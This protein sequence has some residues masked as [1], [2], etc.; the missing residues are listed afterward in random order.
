MS[1]PIQGARYTVL[2]DPPTSPVSGVQYVGQAQ[3]GSL[4]DDP[5]WAIMRLTYASSDL[6]AVEWAA[7][8]NKFNQV[9][10][11]RAALTYS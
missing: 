1:A 7:G 10:D 3:P 5:V 9:W 2:I 6:S 4:T 11:S 8:A